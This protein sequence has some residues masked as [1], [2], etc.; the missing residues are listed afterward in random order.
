M[1]EQGG[2]V[3]VYPDQPVEGS[4]VAAPEPFE[5][6]HDP[7]VEVV[8]D[9]PCEEAQLG[10]VEGPVVVDPASGHRV[11]VG[12]QAG[13]VRPA[14]TVEVP[15]PYLLADSLASLC[16]YGWHEPTKVAVRA[17]E[18]AAPKSE[19][20]EVEAEVL[21]CPGPV[22]V[23][24]E[25]DL[26]VLG[27]QLEP[28]GLK[29]GGQGGPKVVSLVSGSKTSTGLLTSPSS[30]GT[31]LLPRCPASHHLACSVRSSTWFSAASWSCSSPPL[32][33]RPRRTRSRLWS[34]ATS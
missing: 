29:P 15:G 22:R 8:V 20:E 34:S 25:H 5:L 19:P 1:H 18:Q 6:L 33:A 31:G 26:G 30:P 2:P 3:V 14:A 4:G 16:T 12:G 21:G 23:L 10:A 24:A 32:P 11:D 9:A 28:K 7:P 13:Q 27:V 17:F